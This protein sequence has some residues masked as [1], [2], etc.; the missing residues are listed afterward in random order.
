MSTPS[1]NYCC[2]FFLFPVSL[3]FLSVQWHRWRM[4]WW[5]HGHLV[6]AEGGW[7]CWWPS[8]IPVSC[9]DVSNKDKDRYF[10]LQLASFSIIQPPLPQ[11]IYAVGN[12]KAVVVSLHVRSERSVGSSVGQ[13]VSWVCFIHHRHVCSL[14]RFLLLLMCPSCFVGFPSCLKSAAAAVVGRSVWSGNGRGLVVSTAIKCPVSLG[15]CV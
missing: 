8:G 1:L 15:V 14:F 7:Y 13:Q 5:V 6:A 2:F 3:M 11:R 10:L 9:L 4:Q 12:S